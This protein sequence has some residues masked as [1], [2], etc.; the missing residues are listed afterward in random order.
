MKNVHRTAEVAKLFLE[1]GVVVL[2]A[3]AS[4]IHSGREDARQLISN[5]DFIEGYCRCALSVCRERDPN[6]LNGKADS[7]TI[8]DFTGLSS[9]CDAPFEPALMLDADQERAMQSVD[10]LNRFILDKL[11]RVQAHGG[12]G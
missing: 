11:G 5:A 12:Q 1:L 3:M 10:R 4:P 6:G 2:V 8:D 9:P 7:G